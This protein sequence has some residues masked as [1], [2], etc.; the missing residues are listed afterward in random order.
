MNS[1]PALG[2]EKVPVTTADTATLYRTSAVASLMRL[3]PTSIFTIR[4]GAPRR[5]AIVV[6][7]TGSVSETIA[8]KTNAAAH[9]RSTRKCAT[10]ATVRV[11]SSTRPMDRDAIGLRFAFR[12]RG[13]EGR[14][15][16]RRE[17]DQED[18]IRWWP[19]LRHDGNK[20]QREPPED[21]EDRVRHPQAIG[22][23][24]QSGHGREQ[25]EDPELQMP[26]HGAI[27][28]ELH[29]IGRK[30]LRSCRTPG[31]ILPEDRMNI[32]TFIRSR[33]S[34]S[35]VACEGSPPQRGT[36][37]C[38]CRSGRAPW[39]R[40][41]PF[42][43]LRLFSPHLRSLS[44]VVGVPGRPPRWMDISGASEGLWFD[45]RRVCR[46]YVPG[47]EDNHAS[48]LPEE[49]D[50]KYVDGPDGTSC[51]PS[52]DYQH[53]ER[54]RAVHALDSVELDVRGRRRT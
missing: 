14:V 41:S 37:C 2:N 46:K 39:G 3:S 38:T 4:L 15:E 5:P 26:R 50:P 44:G 30:T 8:P 11:V 25:P 17:E 52:A 45:R 10:K 48:V 22:E 51:L 20:A 18:Q 16:E 33:R 35:V 1:S 28:P 19:D 12:S 54:T 47:P 42:D 7:A 21:E 36:G 6:A 27:S 31:T 49:N 23:H 43:R 13:E 32:A 53:F 9:G 40:R 24:H 29:L 34:Y